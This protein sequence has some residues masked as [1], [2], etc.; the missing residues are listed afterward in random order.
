MRKILLLA[1]LMSA[2]VAF[3]VPAKRMWRTVTQQDGT[4]VELML[5]GD[6]NFHYFI[7]RDNVPVVAEDDKYCYA[8]NTGMALVSTGVLAHEPE[9]RTLKDKANIYSM[10]DVERARQFSGNKGMARSKAPAKV[11]STHYLGKRKGLIILANF[12]DKKFWDYT[13]EDNGKATWER[14]NNLANQ[15]GYT[16]EEYGAIGSVH[17][18]YLDQS[19]GKFNLTFDVIGPV[20]LS[21]SSSYYGSNRNGDDAKSPEMILECCQLVDSLVNFNDY[22]WDEDG[23]VE[24]VFVLY[25][26]YGE[27]TGG[28]ANT[29]WPHMWTWK[30]AYKADNSLP[31]KLLFDDAEV[32]VYACSNELYL[33]YGTV[34]M[35]IGTLCHE[36]SHCLG[37]PDLYDTKYMGNFGMGAWDILDS[38]SYNGP[39]GLG[40]V[41][42][43]YTAYERNFAGWMSLIELSDDRRV[44][45]QKPLTE[46]GNA[47]VIYNDA[48]PDEYYILENRDQKGWDEYLPGKGLLVVHVDYDADIW[49]DNLVNTTGFYNSH[50]R[51]TVFH[52]S[53]SKYGGNDAYPYNDNDS[54]TDNSI[55]AATLYNPNNDG[56]K[57]MHKSITE[58]K[59][60]EETGYISFR[61]TNN[62]KEDAIRMQSDDKDNSIVAI[63]TIDG[64]RINNIGENGIDGLPEGV[65]LIK[66]S[67]NKIR[68]I[69]LKQH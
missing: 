43:G 67:D 47:Y 27:A 44:A 7:T 15:E 55:P 22:D 18:Y 13:E 6:E 39:S 20:E 25:A 26:G 48:F 11:K 3:A 45:N 24:E 31:E 4:K 12:S 41:P 54:L 52:A 16:N 63:Y 50:Q 62:N 49:A 66:Y 64:V 42:A 30:E 68:K 40:W 9:D 32:N 35:G 14:Y 34:E 56:Q 61:F 37:L 59:R 17:D 46:K 53:N 58:I 8:R 5:I 28:P 69:N 38:G 10:D 23:I 65:Y 36:F 1:L 57:F 33:N 19:F 29:V 51:L 21:R 2:S 60:D